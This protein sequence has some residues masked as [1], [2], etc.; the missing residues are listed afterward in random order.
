L[1]KQAA[2]YSGAAD[3]E[4]ASTRIAEHEMELKRLLKQRDEL[5]SA[6]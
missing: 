5:L 6:P 4:L 3:D 1:V 2:A